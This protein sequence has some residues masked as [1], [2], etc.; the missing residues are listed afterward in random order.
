MRLEIETSSADAVFAGLVVDDTTGFPLYVRVAH[1][2]IRQI[3]LAD[4]KSRDFRLPSIRRLSEQI[5]TTPATVQQS[6]HYLSGLNFVSS[7]SGIGYYVSV[8]NQQRA[9]RFFYE[10]TRR[11]LAARLLDE[12]AAGRSVEALQELVSETARSIGR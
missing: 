7:K 3:A 6:Y 4:M 1:S 5:K 2:V 9:R 11:V 10:E 8:K 12:L